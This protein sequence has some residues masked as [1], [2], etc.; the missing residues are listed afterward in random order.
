MKQNNTK[1]NL[2]RLLILVILILISIYIY[3]RSTG[4]DYI[5]TIVEKFSTISGVNEQPQEQVDTTPLNIQNVTSKVLTYSP[6]AS[7]TVKTNKEVELEGETK[8]KLYL[9]KLDDEGTYWYVVEFTNVGIG[10]A[11]PKVTLKDKSNNKSEF[12]VEIT[13]QTYGLPF[14]MKQIDDWP[15]TKYTADGDSLRAQVDK[16]HKLVSDYTPLDLVNLS[17]EY[18]LYT[19][20]ASITLRK[21]A[22]DALRV[23]LQQLK[24]DVGQDLLIMSGYRSFNEQYQ[25]YASWLKDY[26][27]EE[28]DKFS[29]RPGYSEHNLGT[30]ID[31]T[32]EAVNNEL[33]NTFNTTAAGQ[34]L[35][36]NAYKYGFVQSYPE[37]K[38]IET[39]YNHEAWHY[40]YIGV[41]NASEFMQSGKTLNEWLEE[42]N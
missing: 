11:T 10:F 23:M 18:L 17:K 28:T 7:V 4:V 32:N 1:R 2:I 24:K 37:G 35:L 42:K 40:R 36:N 3:G 15:D 34:W 30:V 29:A 8:A 22:A 20:N 26:G 16:R 38:E 25:I 6:T 41:D 9:T 33:I 31:F 27:Q 19:N 13:R 12:K 14:G 39:G 21:D 5:Q